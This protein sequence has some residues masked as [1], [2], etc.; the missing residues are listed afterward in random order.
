MNDGNAAGSRTELGAAREYGGSPWLK[1]LPNRTPV[2]YPAISVG[3][4][5]QLS[6]LA[7][8]WGRV[9]H[10]G[11]GRHELWQ[12]LFH[13]PAEAVVFK[14]DVHQRCRIE[15]IAAVVDQGHCESVIG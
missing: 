13:G 9:E 15:M 11:G 14:T 3:L 6:L 2:G 4:G 12:R 7:D 10:G 5:S 8:G 1:E